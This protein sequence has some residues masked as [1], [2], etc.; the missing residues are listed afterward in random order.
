MLESRDAQEESLARFVTDGWPAIDPV[1][2]KPGWHLDAI[3]EHLEAVA[4]GDVRQL[5]INVPPR[6]SK[7]SMVSVAFP[8]WVWAQP[9]RYR[10]PLS[11]PHVQFLFSSYAQTLSI[12]DSVKTRRVITSPWYQERWGRRFQLQ[13][14]QNAKVRFDNTEGGYR[15][16]TSV[17][18][19]LTG[20]GGS[21]IIIDDPHN[22]TEM[23]S[24]AV[25]E[26][27]IEWWDGAMSTRLNDPATGA[28]IVIMQRLHEEDLTG[29]IL[30]KN[31][32]DW[33]HLCLP[34]RYEP[35][36]HC[37]TQIGWSDP[38]SIEGELLCE[39]RFDEVSV[40]NLEANLGPYR[41]AGQLQQRPEPKGGGI[42]KREWW[43]DYTRPTF[44]DLKFVLASLDPAYTE[45]EENDPS[46][47]SLW[48]VY[49]TEEGVDMAMLI[50]CWSLHLDIN[51]LVQKVAETCTTYGVDVLLIES[52]A[53][54]LSVAQE[55]ERLHSHEPWSVTTMDPKGDKVARAYSIQGLLESGLVAAPTEKSWADKLISQ[56]ASFPKAKHDDLVD[57][58]TQG[59]KFLRSEGYLRQA[60]ER[61]AQRRAEMEHTKPLAPLYEV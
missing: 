1:P 59:L 40:A 43:V 30:A 17:D 48:G 8:A 41:A 55:I 44:P 2:F 13:G 31:N 25:R 23:E 12:R 52:K 4:N 50:Y 24:D 51:P 42:L 35:D 19:A 29:H 53:S 45:D 47:L 11:G 39:D 61:R 7:S 9:E 54:G 27:T 58:M 56:A 5:I 22:A 49:T 33:V 34:M 15:L 18:G 60:A 3:A 57:T 36:R 26:S 37:V 38:R 46:A 16:A 10:G 14:D 32:P 28:Y 20:E 6:T 21:I